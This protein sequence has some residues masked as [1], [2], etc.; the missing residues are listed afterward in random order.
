MKKLVCLPLPMAKMF[1]DHRDAVGRVT[2][3]FFEGIGGFLLSEQ[4]V[5]MFTGDG[6]QQKQHWNEKNS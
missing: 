5:S 6:W 4:M 1:K 3:H 2:R